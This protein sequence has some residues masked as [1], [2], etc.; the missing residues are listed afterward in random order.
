LQAGQLKFHP[1]EDFPRMVDKEFKRPKEQ[2]WLAMQEIVR[3]LA[4]P[5]K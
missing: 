4:Q 3:T 1:L 5:E 2:N